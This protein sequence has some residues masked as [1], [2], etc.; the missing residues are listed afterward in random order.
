M[1]HLLQVWTSLS[2]TEQAAAIGVLVSVLMGV[3][4]RLRPAWFASAEETA[5]WARMLTAILTCAAGVLVAQ[6]A[7]GPI[8][9]AQFALAWVVAYGGSEI[10]HTVTARTTGALTQVKKQALAEINAALS[11]WDWG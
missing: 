11:L 3:V 10:T 2:P 6:L 4:R 7:A 8:D 1:T 5:R 9:W